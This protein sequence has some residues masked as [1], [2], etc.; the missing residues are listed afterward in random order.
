V[1][2]NKLCRWCFAVVNDA[3]LRSGQ[4]AGRARLNAELNRGSKKSRRDGAE[5]GRIN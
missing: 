1:S 4:D 3:G 2:R 5:D